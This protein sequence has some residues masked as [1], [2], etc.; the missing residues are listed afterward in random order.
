M[1]I[2]F[3]KGAV[4][5]QS[6]K[7]KQWLT[8]VSDYTTGAT[9]LPTKI[10]DD[11]FVFEPPLPADVISGKQEIDHEKTAKTDECPEKWGA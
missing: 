8:R 4:L 2:P 11:M 9:N 3:W 5:L 6:T 7:T 1:T 10:N